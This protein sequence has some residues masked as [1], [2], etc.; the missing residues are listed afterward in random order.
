MLFFT[1]LVRWWYTY[2][3]WAGPGR[4]TDSQRNFDRKLV[5]LMD[6]DAVRSRTIRVVL[7]RALRLAVVYRVPPSPRV[8]RTG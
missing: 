4:F 5:G 3:W 6:H 7:G 2:E 8:R 1:K